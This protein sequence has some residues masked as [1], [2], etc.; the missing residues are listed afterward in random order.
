MIDDRTRRA[1]REPMR[2]VTTDGKEHREVTIERAKDHFDAGSKT[3]AVMQCVRL[4]PE[5]DA[6]AAEVLARDDFT[7]E[8]KREIA[9][10][11]S[12]AGREFQIVE[13][14]ERH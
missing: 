1:V 2:I 4:A 11:L 6:A 13:Q 7:T 9:E 10:T 5:L 14:V 12:V 8:Q 3:A